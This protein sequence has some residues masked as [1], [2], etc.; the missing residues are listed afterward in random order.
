LE[1]I[2]D[3]RYDQTV[4]NHEIDFSKF[5]VKSFESIKDPVRWQ[6]NIRD[7]WDR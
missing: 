1:I 6:Q 2:E 4:N 7:E 3:K 5:K